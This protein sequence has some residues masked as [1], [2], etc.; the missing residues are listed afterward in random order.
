[1][2]DQVDK[3]GRAECVKVYFILRNSREK[4]SG[5]S[6]I[7]VSRSEIQML[8][9]LD[10]DSLRV[11]SIQSGV[12]FLSYIRHPAGPSFILLHY[13]K[14]CQSNRSRM[15]KRN[16]NEKFTLII[17]YNCL[18]ICVDQCDQIY[19]KVPHQKSFQKK[20]PHRKLNSVIKSCTFTP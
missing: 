15:K 13:Y 3:R 8:S 2:M 14:T 17:Q 5:Y 6:T 20:A 18:L 12:R 11:D 19:R 9:R 16:S 10:D 1:M 7:V 4:R